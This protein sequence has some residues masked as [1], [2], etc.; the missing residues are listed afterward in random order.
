VATAKL[1]ELG[2]RMPII[3]VTGNVLAA[4]KA[5]FIAHGAN[6]VLH[7]PLSVDQ[8]KAEI[9]SIN[10]LHGMEEMKVY[11]EEMV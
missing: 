5:F 11:G 4:D 9:S 2:Y 6:S 8:L 1:R 10:A 3:G 7:K